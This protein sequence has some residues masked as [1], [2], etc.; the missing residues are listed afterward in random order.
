MGL[1]LTELN[2]LTCQDFM[3]FMEMWMGD[4]ESG[5]KQATQEDIN[6]FMG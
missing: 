2:T 6:R 1:S 4:D 3:D 5:G